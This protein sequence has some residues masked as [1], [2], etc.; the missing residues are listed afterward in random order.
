MLGLIMKREIRALVTS[1]ANTIVTIV[2]FVLIIV[3][4]VVGK[5]LLDD[6]SSDAESNVSDTQTLT[7]AVERSSQDL[8][9]FVEAGNPEATVAVIDD[10]TAETWLTDMI[11]ADE[12]TDA[13]AF[14]TTANGLGIYFADTD[15]AMDAEIGI[16]QV[17][18]L[19]LADQAAN[20]T[21]PESEYQRLLTEPELLEPIIVENASGNL[22]LSDPV[23]YFVSIISLVLL[24][25]A[26]MSGLTTIST[27]VV[28]E[29]A[30]RVV[31]ILLSSVRPR[32]LLMGKILGIGSFVL[33]QFMIFLVAG[34][35][36]ASI[37]GIWVE[38]DLTATIVWT[39]VWTIVGFFIFAMVAGALA[40]TVSRQ[41]DL[42]AITAP[43]SFGALIPLYLA[44]FLVPALP[45][46]TITKVLSMVPFISS[47]MMPVRTSYGVTSTAEQLIAL[48][49]ALVCFPLLAMLAGKI[50]ESS[51]LRTGKRISIAEALKSAK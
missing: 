7:I 26:I 4:G 33:G 15:Y 11:E 3:A 29:K 28:E 48:A 12:D 23:G 41:E 21:I 42:G 37:A 25:T 18:G 14:G 20:G 5:F 34:V 32:T 46:A 1:R 10:G 44:L 24:S 45:D 17:Y 19:Y 36:A 22:L 8:V 35:I 27:G 50:Y 51:I 16:K 43:L 38:L 6:D 40:S 47:F 13:Y 9:P 31:E 39:I 2:M 49:I 30:S